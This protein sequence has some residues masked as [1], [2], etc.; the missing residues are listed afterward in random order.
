MAKVDVNGP[1]AEPLFNFL[2]SAKGGI[3]GNDIK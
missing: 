2:K 3:L 1:G